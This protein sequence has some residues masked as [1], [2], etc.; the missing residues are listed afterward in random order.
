[1]RW[2]VMLV[3]LSVQARCTVWSA[4]RWAAFSHRI[5][6]QPCPCFI[7]SISRMRQKVARVS[8][9]SSVL[10]YQSCIDRYRQLVVDMPPPKRVVVQLICGDGSGSDDGVGAD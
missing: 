2:I 1:M 4:R 8:P 10:T 5:I 6:V 7:C 3:R 9:I